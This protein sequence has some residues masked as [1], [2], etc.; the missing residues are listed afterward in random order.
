MTDKNLTLYFV[1]SLLSVCKTKASEL[2]VNSNLTL[3]P[4][5]SPLSHAIRS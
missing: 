5:G 2:F 1:L 4:G 3:V